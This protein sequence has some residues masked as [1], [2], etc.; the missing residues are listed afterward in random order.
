[1][2]S[3][4]MFSRDDRTG[5]PSQTAMRTNIVFLLFCLYAIALAVRVLIFS[6][7]DPM[8][9]DLLE[10]LGYAAIGSGALYLGRRKIPEKEVDNEPKQ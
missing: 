5:R 1:M 3:W 2:M 8:A 10:I 9:V 7:P 6:A 4:K